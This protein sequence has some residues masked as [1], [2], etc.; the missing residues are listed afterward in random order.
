MRLLINEKYQGR[1]SSF[2][3]K[4]QKERIKKKVI[5]STTKRPS[6]LNKRR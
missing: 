6:F 4:V 5:E 1:G 3:Q 2:L